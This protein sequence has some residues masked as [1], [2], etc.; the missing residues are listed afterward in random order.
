MNKKRIIAVTGGIGSG[1][2]TVLNQL[3]KLGYPVF[4][5]DEILNEVYSDKAVKEELKKMFPTAII[6]NLR[7]SVDRKTLS[8]LCFS[9]PEN[10]KKL[11]A[12]THPYIL[13]KAINFL[14]KQ[15]KLSG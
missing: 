6:G 9:S 5:C 4:S 1:K 2:S 10:R 12:I 15:M 13:K 3:S 8:N 11:E 7:L 14:R